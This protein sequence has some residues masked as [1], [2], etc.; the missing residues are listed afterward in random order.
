MPKRSPTI[1][2]VLSPRSA[3]VVT[4]IPLLF[5]VTT[6]RLRRHDETVMLLDW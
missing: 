5:V 1:A 4:G 6:A 2:P 3:I